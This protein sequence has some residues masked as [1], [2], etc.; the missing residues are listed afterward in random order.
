MIEPKEE[1]ECSRVKRGLDFVSWDK[2]YAKYH[3]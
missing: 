2:G 3:Q 1:V